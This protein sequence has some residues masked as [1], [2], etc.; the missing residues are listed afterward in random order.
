MHVLRLLVQAQVRRHRARPVLLLH[1]GGHLPHHGHHLV[2]QTFLSVAEVSERGDVLLGDHHDVDRVRGVGVMKGQDPFGLL[3]PLDGYRAGQRLMAVEVGDG[4]G[5]GHKRTPSLG[6]NVGRAPARRGRRA[7]ADDSVATG[8]PA[9][10]IAQLPSSERVF[11]HVGRSPPELARRRERIQLGPGGVGE[12]RADGEGLAAGA[13]DLTADLFQ[14]LGPA[15][16]ERHG[17]PQSRQPA[18]RCPPDAA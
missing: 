16:A 15:G 5:T 3:H 12:I 17:R 10:E 18:C 1:S 14:S 8:H 11:V 7:G 13:V 2:Q 9:A 6:R 4:R